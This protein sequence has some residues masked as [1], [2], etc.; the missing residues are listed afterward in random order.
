MKK[1]IILGINNDCNMKLRLST[2]VKT[3]L[4]LAG[5]NFTACNVTDVQENTTDSGGNKKYYAQIEEPSGPK[6]RTYADEDL[7]VL[8]NADDRVSIFEKN[9]YNQQ[10]KFDGQDG[11]NSGSFSIIPV[12]GYFTGNELPN[13]YS[14]YPYKA[15]NGISNSGVLSITL[16]DTLTYRKDSFGPGD[17]VMVAATEGNLLV[18]KN[19]GGYLM[20]KLYG[21]SSVT[22]ITLKGNNGELLSGKANVSIPLDGAPSLEMDPGQS[23]T[24][25]TLQCDNPVQLS[26]SADNY[27]A[28]WF[29]L[30]PVTFSEGITV[31]VKKNDGTVF[32]K[33][34]TGS[35]TIERN[36]RSRMAPLQVRAGNV[37][38]VKYTARIQGNA[39]T[40]TILNDGMQFLWQPTDYISLIYENRL[41]SLRNTLAE[42]A[43]SAVFSGEIGGTISS[44]TTVWAAY[45]NCSILSGQVIMSLETVQTADNETIVRIPMV[46]SFTTDILDFYPVAG[47]VSFSVTRDDIRSVTIRGNGG[48]PL[49]GSFTVGVGDDGIPYVS[50]V[51]TPQTILKLIPNGRSTFEVGR[52]YYFVSLPAHFTN[53]I[54]VEIN[55]EN[56]QASWTSTRDLAISRGDCVYL[57][58]IENDAIF[59]E[60]VV[61]DNEIW[62]KTTKGQAV[63][64]KDGVESFGAAMVS[65]TYSDG[66]GVIVFD[67]PVTRIP[68]GAFYNTALFEV[69]LPETVIEIGDEA[70]CYNREMDDF[71]FPSLVTYVGKNAFNST[72]LRK[73]DLPASLVKIGA[74]AFSNTQ[75]EEVFI[76]ESVEVIGEAYIE[77]GIL[78][79]D[80]AFG[81]STLKRF[82]GKF[83]SPDGRCLIVRDSLRA[84]AP[85]GL[86]EY[87]FHSGIKYICG[88]INWSAGYPL[89]LNNDLEEVG[90]NAFNWCSNLQGDVT[91]PKLKKIGRRAFRN[92]RNMTSFYVPESLEYCGAG[93]FQSTTKLERFTGPN[94]SEDGRCLVLDGELVAFAYSGATE[95]VIPANVT[96]IRGKNDFTTTNSTLAGYIVVKAINPP[97]LE[98]GTLPFSFA[99]PPIIRKII[100]PAVSLQAYKEA[101][102]WSDYASCIVSE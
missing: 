97:V 96:R 60:I 98:D 17:N 8:W 80:S 13:T 50:E 23:G 74:A 9:T 33:S 12:S 6:V 70:F 82:S 2:V 76:P 90:P 24:T 77:N 61:P 1:M 48:E 37:H 79:D 36:V 81:C 42:P 39:Q 46:A 20:I 87:T 93:A 94:I 65:N 64:F 16:P 40:R 5:I 29:V 18:Y 14:V 26:N 28:F 86:E 11:D 83:A 30:P 67:G 63:V 31:S 53:G 15:S 32:E 56:E 3:L 55:T 38:T 43:E 84:F 99:T 10:F 57:G 71:K 52:K 91:L 101:P 51:S 69:H 72:G 92:C 78:Y 68:P 95:C 88:Y 4:F 89:H 58:K 25:L 35:L 44:G 73:V 49:S 19:L 47:L 59:Q 85:A 21:S 75:L 62:Y 7:Y 100:V 102:G 45:P 22:S 34:T 27:T 66:K 54:T 41:A